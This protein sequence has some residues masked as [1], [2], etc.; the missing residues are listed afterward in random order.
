MRQCATVAAAGECIIGLAGSV[1][2]NARMLRRRQAAC[3][4]VRDPHIL[5]LG[6]FSP[7]HI[8]PEQFSLIIF[9]YMA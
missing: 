6:I 2:A 1:D 3:G 8:P 5:L 7:G 4:R 9:P